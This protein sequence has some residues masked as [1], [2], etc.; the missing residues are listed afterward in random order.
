M[1]HKRRARLRFLAPQVLLLVLLFG[2]VVAA[3]VAARQPEPAASEEPWQIVDAGNNSRIDTSRRR[4]CGAGT[5][6]S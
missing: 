3:G 2:A 6:I 1:S 5:G 4:G